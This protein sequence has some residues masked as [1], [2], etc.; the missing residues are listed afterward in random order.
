MYS[1][2]YN[3]TLQTCPQ[4]G[5]ACPGAGSTTR[6]C[7]PPRPRGSW[8]WQACPGWPSRSRSETWWTPAPRPPCHWADHGDQVNIENTG[9]FNSFGVTLVTRSAAHL[10]FNSL[11]STVTIYQ[12]QG[13]GSSSDKVTKALPPQVLSEL[14][15]RVVHFY[16]CYFYFIPEGAKLLVNR[17]IQFSNSVLPSNQQQKSNHH[18]NLF[19][20]NKDTRLCELVCIT[21]ANPSSKQQSLPTDATWLIF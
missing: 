7:C 11:R 16:F 10:K 18:P 20:T 1:L 8:G 12:N 6:S 4:W 21:Q 13:H 14:Y 19:P 5:G 15:Q 17:I 2:H 3:I 9:D